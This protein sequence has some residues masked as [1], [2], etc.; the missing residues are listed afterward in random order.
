MIIEKKLLKN[1][2]SEE[3]DRSFDQS[4][5]G[6]VMADEIIE[7]FETL[8]ESQKLNFLEKFINHIN[9]NTNIK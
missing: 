1:I 4:Q 6:F 8:N 7:K 3:I 2:I 5:D 9:E